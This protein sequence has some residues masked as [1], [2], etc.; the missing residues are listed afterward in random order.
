MSAVAHELDLDLPGGRLHAQR[1]GA[2]GDDLVLCAHGLSANMHGFDF[3]AARLAGPGRQVVALDLRG[4]GRSET[5]PPGTYGLPAHARDVLDA[6][7]TLGAQ[8]FALLGWSM[9]ALIGLHVAAQAPERLEALVLLDHAGRE[10]EAAVAAVR[11]GLDRLD[12]VVPDERTYLDAIRAVGAAVPW[13]EHW[14]RF[15]RYELGPVQ[16]G[17]SPV[18][19]KAAALED[20][21]ARGSH[22]VGQL[23]AGVTMPVLLVRATEPLGGGLIVPA[24]QRDAFAAAVPHAQVIDVDR[25][26]YGV[27]TDDRV[28]EA[29]AAL[30]DG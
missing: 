6:A 28:A 13:D 21:D 8:R 2:E 3:L 12:A 17:L 22:D 24:D 19:S 30:L 5:T 29:V 4:R 26:H 15:Y 20:L 11:K 23:W 1:F 25:N 27:M 18:T 14:E 10:D 16:G 9:G 7:S